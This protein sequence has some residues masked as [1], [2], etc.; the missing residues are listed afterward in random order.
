M[1]GG[2]AATGAAHLAAEL[3]GGGGEPQP[4]EDAQQVDE[5]RAPAHGEEERPLGVA[6]RV[7]RHP[8]PK[9]EHCAGPFWMGSGRGGET[10]RQRDAP[11]N[12]PWITVMTQNPQRMRNCNHSMHTHSALAIA[13]RTMKSILVNP[14]SY[15]V[16][17]GG[18]VGTS[19][20]E[21]AA[22]AKASWAV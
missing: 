18:S 2:G 6:V 19:F 14:S 20:V 1:G 3:E 8:E 21:L 12:V 22:V 13:M 5:E 11:R 17:S 10:R 9:E 4:P 16:R 15:S 7:R